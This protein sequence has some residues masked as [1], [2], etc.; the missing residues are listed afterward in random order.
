MVTTSTV[1]VLV[2]FFVVAVWSGVNIAGTRLKDILP[3]IGEKEDPE[4]WEQIH[5]DVING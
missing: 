5:K 4:N 1:T 2:A 3:N